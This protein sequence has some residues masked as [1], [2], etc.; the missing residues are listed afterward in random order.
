MSGPS[1]TVA[2]GPPSG[3][4]ADRALVDLT[5]EDDRWLDLLAA[6]GSDPLARDLDIVARTAL[7]DAS[8]PSGALEIGVLLTDDRAVRDLNRAYRGVDRPTNVLSFPMAGPMIGPPLTESTATT[9][10]SPPAPPEAPIMLGDIAM[11]FETVA[12]E[13]R[14]EG[15]TP[16]DH[17]YHLLVHGVLHLLG[18]DHETDQDAERMERLEARIVARFGI[19]DPYVGPDDRTA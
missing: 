19:A 17:L 15:K 5:V 14:T 11:A 18:Y 2:T 7:A 8:G 9:D 16:R 1:T 3:Q 13:A 12:A 10:P 4:P 6:A